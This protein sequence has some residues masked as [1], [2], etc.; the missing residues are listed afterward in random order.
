MSAVSTQRSVSSSIS[1]LT[2][3]EIMKKSCNRLCLRVGVG[4]DKN[5]PTPTPTPVKS[6]DSGRLRLRLRSPGLRWCRYF[7]SIT[8]LLKTLR[9][10]YRGYVKIIRRKGPR[11]FLLQRSASIVFNTSIRHC[12]PVQFWK[13]AGLCACSNKCKRTSSLN[14]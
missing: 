14:V 8:D 5:L 11:A 10:I 7:L 3:K 2:R 1:T 6:T 13:R 4:V 12:H 9:Y